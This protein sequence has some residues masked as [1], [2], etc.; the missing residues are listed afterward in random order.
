VTVSHRSVL[1][2]NYDFEALIDKSISRADFRFFSHSPLCTV[3]SS[4]ARVHNHVSLF[5][6]LSLG[7]TIE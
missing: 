2:C 3:G 7:T 1:L 4:T 6:I 5:K